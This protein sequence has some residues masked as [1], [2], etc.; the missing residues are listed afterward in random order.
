[1]W[2]RAFLFALYVHVVAC[3]SLFPG[4][5]FFDTDLTQAQWI[6]APESNLTS[7]APPGTIGFFRT[8]TSPA[9]KTA[10][11]ASIAIT[12]D[13]NFTLWVNGHVVGATFP[14]IPA[15]DDAWKDGQALI[16]S[17]NATTNTLTAIAVNFADN[18]TVGGVTPAG[19]LAFVRVFYTDG[20]TTT[21]TTD[22]SWK[23]TTTLP[24]DWPLPADTS[25]FSTAEVSFPY[26]EGP[27]GTSVTIT[28]ADFSALDLINSQWI[29]STSSAAT[30]APAG[31]VG[32]RKTVPSPSDKSP[33]YAIIVAA[34]DNFF[35]FYLNGRF[36][37]SPP[38][39]PNSADETVYG[40]EY[41]SRVTVYDLAPSSNTF[42]F[43]AT[44][45][46]SQTSNTESPA[47]FIAA[48][49]IAYTDGTTDVIYTNDTWLQAT[50]P[51]SGSALVAMPDTS[52]DTVDVL[53]EYGMSP[54]GFVS[55]AD[56]LDASRVFLSGND[57]ED[58]IVDPGSSAVPALSATASDTP[59]F[60]FAQTFTGPAGSAPSSSSS[61]PSQTSGASG[62]RL[63]CPEV[64]LLFVGLAQIAAAS[65]TLL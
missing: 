27:W 44:N 28:Q 56:T 45:F 19:F 30:S 52:L 22:T 11:A 24:S 16:A 54:W 31:S 59:S 33:A 51:S 36:V 3:I 25:A 1:M 58:G 20:S 14:G 47:G 2:L 49:Q 12:A 55:V 60:S 53:G 38:D 21:F 37:S 23:T 13:N 29:W 39:D 35:A 7:T 64:L 48:I 26:G 5:T 40:W 43:F 17:L 6:W 62:A 32:F 34:A 50:S 18:S 57:V 10:S 46:L 4:T 15:V 65:Q 61:G 9:G 41:A 42:D 8:F 63:V